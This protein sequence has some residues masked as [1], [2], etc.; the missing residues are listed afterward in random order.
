MLV[1][2]FIQRETHL[3]KK[4]WSRTSCVATTTES[5]MTRPVPVSPFPILILPLSGN[6]VAGVIIMMTNRVARSSS[7]LKKGKKKVKTSANKLRVWPG[8]GWF[9]RRIPVGAVTVWKASSS[10]GPT[11]DESSRVL[12]FAAL[13]SHRPEGLNTHTTKVSHFKHRCNFLCDPRH[14]KHPR[15]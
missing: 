6:C 7:L 11:A 5:L 9:L 13:T 4:I 2:A 14:L 12:G 15:H 3:H 1:W 8:L 10:P